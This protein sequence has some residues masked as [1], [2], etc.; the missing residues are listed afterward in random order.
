MRRTWS[1]RPPPSASSCRKLATRSVPSPPD[2]RFGQV[3]VR[4]DERTPGRLED[5]VR[6]RVVGGR[7]RR[8]VT[9]YVLRGQRLAQ[10][11]TER[12]TGRG[13]LGLRLLGRE[14]KLEVERAVARQ[15]AQQVIEHRQAAADVALA[16]AVER[17]ANASLF[18]HP[19]GGR[20]PSNQGTARA[21]SGRRRTGALSRFP[22]GFDTDSRPQLP[23]LLRA[24]RGSAGDGCDPGAERRHEPS[25]D[26]P[27][28]RRLPLERTAG[29]GAEGLSGREDR[30]AD[31][32]HEDRRGRADRP[33]E[34]ASRPTRHRL[35]APPARASDDGRAR[36]HGDA[37]PGLPVRVAV[38]RH[39]GERGA[40][41]CAAGGGRDQDRRRRHRRGRDA[42]GPGREVARDLGRRP[43][44]A[45]A[46]RTTTAMA[47]SSPPSPRARSTTARGSPASAATHSSSW[48]GPSAQTAASAT[49]TRPPRSSTRST[50]ARRS[51]ISRSAARAPPRSSRRPCSTRR[52]TT[53]C[54]SPRPGNEYEAGQP[55]RVPRRRAP[56]AR[57]ERTG[58]VRPVGRSQHDRGQARVLLEHRLADLPRSPR[59]K[60]LRRPRARPP[61]RSGG[62]ATP[63]PAPRR[64]STAGRAGRRS[65]APRSPARRRSSGPRTRR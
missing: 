20:H 44:P 19:V 17:H 38:R 51:S 6:Q 57:L 26:D 15:Q 41:G 24:A 39:P 27:R 54:S 36:A 65:R 30:P 55:D 63:C 58:R 2:P 9:P 1:V 34:R 33:R 14:L 18:S 25:A 56:A 23:S 48:S 10:R 35:R 49:S 59:R 4:D 43:P 5:D 47:R 40:R 45:R 3:D 64:A 13:D 37:P 22:C 12:L 11:L 21:R 50:T 29:D 52:A 60:R 8:P 31:P 46:S 16:R 42:S 62:R 28:R 61:R 7:D 53:C 32:P